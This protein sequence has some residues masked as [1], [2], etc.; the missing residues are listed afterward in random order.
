MNEISREMKII[1]V[2]VVVLVLFLGY[3]IVSK[4][5]KTETKDAIVVDVFNV[6]NKDSILDFKDLMGD[7]KEQFLG[8][9][10]GEDKNPF[11]EGANK[12]D[13]YFEAQLDNNN[14]NTNLDEFK[15]DSIL[16]ANKRKAYP[17][18]TKGNQ[19]RSTP[20]NNVNE[21]E[22]T[23]KNMDDFF[24]KTPKV[25]EEKKTVAAPSDAFIYTSISGD[26][27]VLNNG[28]VELILNKDA[29]IYGKIYKKNTFL[30]GTAKFGVNRIYLE[31]TNINHIPVSL[32]AYDTQD[33][34]LGI[35]T[36]AESLG[37][38]TFNEATTDAVSDVNVGGIRVGE[39]VKNI[40]RKKQKIKKV[41]LLNNYKLILKT[42]S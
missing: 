33:G 20:T 42:D 31:I 37:S 3:T 28:R 39:T 41:A 34:N 26:Q 12:D 24:N 32:K 38:E 6:N 4:T 36:E 9:K 13:R 15:I 2:G 23:F 5:S 8:D 21:K 1:L 27:T 11:Y 10:R 35:Y 17:N 18:T 19:T 14:L 22:N 16:N 30:Y 25:I 7:E 40:F 29:L